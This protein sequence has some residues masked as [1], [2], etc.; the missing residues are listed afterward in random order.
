[1]YDNNS[2]LL[3]LEYNLNAIQQYILYTCEVFVIQ[4]AMGPYIKL[5]SFRRLHASNILINA[6]SFHNILTYK[7]NFS[8]CF[9]QLSWITKIT[10]DVSPLRFHWLTKGILFNL[11][12]GLRCPSQVHR[13][14]FTF[15]NT[16]NT[17]LQEKTHCLYRMI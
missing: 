1:M 13:K 6:F 11:H 2:S 17:I 4:L 8:C 7:K 5:R 14:I 10:M 9:T 15:S 3:S 16:T 12:E